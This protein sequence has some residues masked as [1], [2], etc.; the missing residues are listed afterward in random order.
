MVVNG[1]LGENDL[2]SKLAVLSSESGTAEGA[3]QYL[4]QLSLPSFSFVHLVLCFCSVPTVIP[5]SATQ[6]TC[7]VPLLSRDVA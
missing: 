1:L 4:W 5:I 3:G 6:G 2:N 7:I